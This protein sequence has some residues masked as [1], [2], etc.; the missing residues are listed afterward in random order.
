MFYEYGR[1]VRRGV[2]DWAN[3]SG[4]WR[5]MEL[6]PQESRVT[7]DLG[8]YFD[9]V[10]LW[11]WK[12]DAI[13]ET[14]RGWGIPIIEVGATDQQEDAGPG[15][16]RLRITFDRH[17]INRLA[18]EH[19]QESGIECAGYIGRNLRVDDRRVPRVEDL[20]Q[21]VLD[22]GLEWTE[23]DTRD[24]HPVWDPTLLWH[25]ASI[26]GLK[27]YLRQ[28]PGPTGLLCQDDYLGVMVYEVARDLGLGVPGDVAIL[29]QGDRIIGRYG[30]CPLSTVKIPGE[31]IGHQ[32]AELL[33]RWMSGATPE[34]VSRLVPCREIA[35]RQ[36]T[37]GLSGRLAIERAKRHF[38]RHAVEGVTVGELASIAGCAPATLRQ[39]FRS[40]YGFEIAAE[41]RSRRQLEAIRL[42]AD[43]DLETRE[44]GKR[45]GFPAASNFFNFVRRQTGMGP[46]EFRRSVRPGKSGA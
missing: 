41:A 35:M 15:S 13:S 14:I 1:S 19:F 5:L 31:D 34:R 24:H 23:F 36:S 30:P 12:Q 18:V 46:A 39:R 37:G 32:A 21:R 26:P 38:D 42:L 7:A 9:G 10:I 44:I 27:D 2:M 17:S 43:S 22:A 20:R 8:R 11:D 33:D 16:R 3:R 6:D 45:C 28:L 29:G 25:G 40:A 4:P